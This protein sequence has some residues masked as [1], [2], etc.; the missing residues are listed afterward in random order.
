VEQGHKHSGL[1]IASFVIATLVGIAMF[2]AFVVA[3][4]MEVS[5]PGGIDESSLS[6]VLLG[7]LMIGLMIVDLVAVGLG[8]GGLVQKDR[9]KV[10]AVLGTVFSVATIVGTVL[11]IIIG[12]MM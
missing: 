7:L 11:L 2:A 4:M 3:G 9:K 5:T 1:G 8:I 12:N 10:F 6:A